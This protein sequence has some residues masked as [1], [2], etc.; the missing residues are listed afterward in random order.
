VLKIQRSANGKIIFTLCGRIEGGDLVELRRLLA[1]EK[2]DQHI[3]LDLKNVTIVS[4]NAVKFLAHCESSSIQL[5]NCPGYI[6]EWIRSDRA[7]EQ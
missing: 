7:S 2:A 5:M 1:G 6:R 3:V 4:G